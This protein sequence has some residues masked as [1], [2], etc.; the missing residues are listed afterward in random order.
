L[1]EDI[2]K[3]DA[4]NKVFQEDLQQQLVDGN[5]KDKERHDEMSSLLRSQVVATNAASETQKSILDEMKATREAQ[6]LVNSQNQ[7]VLMAL[8]QKL[9]N[10]SG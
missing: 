1:F 2:K 8:L 6:A 3:S 4:E 7:N 10:G 5:A 9:T